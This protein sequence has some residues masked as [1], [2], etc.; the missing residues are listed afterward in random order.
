[1]I[2]KIKQDAPGKPVRVE[3]AHKPRNGGGV[4]LAEF[5]DLGGG[6][7]SRAVEWA[8]DKGHTVR[9]GRQKG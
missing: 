6:G 2:V 9:D 4:T 5:T 3:R 8:E 7:G 1:M